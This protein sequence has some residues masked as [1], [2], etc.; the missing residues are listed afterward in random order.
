MCLG[1]RPDKSVVT[2]SSMSSATPLPLAPRVQKSTLRLDRGH[3]IVHC[4]RACA[5]VEERMIVLGISNPDDLMGGQSHL[6]EG[7]LEAAALVHS[8]RQHHD[9]VAIEDDLK[10]EA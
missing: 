7:G 8:R 9:R 4:N 1:A 10:F 6:A 2:S 3:G 5:D